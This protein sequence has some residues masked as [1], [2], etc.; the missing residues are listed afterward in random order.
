PAG[1]ACRACP[2]ASVAPGPGAPP[3]GSSVV[4]TKDDTDRRPRAPASPAYVLRHQEAYFAEAQR[5]SGTGSFGWNVATGEIV[6]SEG[7]FGIFEYDPTT[8]PTAQRV[9]ERIHPD[10]VGLVKRTMDLA[11]QGERKLDL[12][13]RLLLPDGSVKS[14]HAV[15]N[16]VSDAAGNVEF[17]G[18]VMYVTEQE[19]T[20]AALEAALD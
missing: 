19:R 17:V 15:A 10:D 8:T 6:W 14:L 18:E 13:C 16:A 3:L 20:K 12:A 5:L 11:L 2:G 7:T 1:A 4:T 9:L